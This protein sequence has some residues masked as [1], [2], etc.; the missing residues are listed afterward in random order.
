[1]DERLLVPQPQS[2]FSTN[3]TRSPSR[4]ASRKM[5]APVIPPPITITSHG[6]S[7]SAQISSRQF[8]AHMVLAPLTLLLVSGGKSAATCQKN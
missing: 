2:R 1:L 5:P 7:S 3:S 8:F 4:V 6:W